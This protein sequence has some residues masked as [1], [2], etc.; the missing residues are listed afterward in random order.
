M[1]AVLGK[2]SLLTSQS[3]FQIELTGYSTAN[4]REFASRTMYVLNSIPQEDWPGRRMLGEWLFHRL[5]QVRKLGRVIEEIKR[6]ASN[7]HKRDFEYLWVYLQ[8]YLVEER[9]DQ[10]ALSIESALKTKAPKDTKPTPKVA[11]APAKAVPPK[12][13]PPGNG[14]SPP[15]LVADPK[16]APKAK[17]EKGKGKGKGK[18]PLAAEQ[19]SKTPCVFF[20]MPSGCVHGDK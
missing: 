9:E 4:L 3:V 8:E 14:K 17:G 7:S 19:K 10:N 6:S 18:T 12:P 15:A 1:K 16:P 11:G 2:G 20:Q 5:K 13:S